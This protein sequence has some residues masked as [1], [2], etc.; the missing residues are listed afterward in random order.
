M[1]R[2]T[3]AAPSLARA[4]DPCRIGSLT[5]LF[6]FTQFEFAGPLALADGRYVVRDGE[7]E[8]VLVI[9]TH[10]APPPG[11]RRRRRARHAKPDEPVPELPLAVA[12]VVRAFEPFEREDAASAW[13]E[14]STAENSV[15]KLVGEGI[16]VLNR[17]LHANAVA[18]GDPHGHSLVAN[19]AVTIRIGYGSGEEV[20]DGVFAAAR[21]VDPGGSSASRRR[22]RDKE[23][24]PQQRLAA[25]LGG[26][27]QLDASE[28][29]LLRARADLDAGRN[30]E[31]ALQ[32]RVG[33]EALLVELRDAVTDPGHEEDMATIESRRQEVGELANRALNGD[34]NAKQ[35]TAVEDLLALC[36]RVLRRRRVLE[37]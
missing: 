27:E 14:R 4:T 12:M 15:D 17:A 35:L 13:L 29:L 37:G 16:G 24:R 5:R 7:R 36:E 33:L 6:G 8:Q 32:L 2:A 19:H 25:V 18:S 31:A 11:R 9:E 3:A 10:G 30:R 22:R 1:A 21:L 23:L 28:T 20:A 34:L 26:R